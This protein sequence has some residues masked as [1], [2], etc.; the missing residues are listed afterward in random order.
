MSQ[1]ARIRARRAACPGRAWF[2]YVRLFYIGEHDMRCDADRLSIRLQ[3]PSDPDL[4]LQFFD[5]ARHAPARYTKAREPVMYFSTYI[6]RF[7]MQ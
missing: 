6:A 5:R 4:T 7:A 1:C 3:F 2:S